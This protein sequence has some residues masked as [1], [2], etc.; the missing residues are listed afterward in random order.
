MNLIN[1]LNQLIWVY[2]IGDIGFN[3]YDLALSIIIEECYFKYL[4]DLS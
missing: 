4:K 2:K 3:C 1:N